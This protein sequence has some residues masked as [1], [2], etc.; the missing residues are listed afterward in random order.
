MHWY[1]AGCGQRY[2]QNLHAAHRWLAIVLPKKENTKT[3]RG[4][5]VDDIK[6]KAGGGTESQSSAAATSPSLPPS[7]APLGAELQ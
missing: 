5:I 3:H 2:C 7:Q 4:E 1:C 6:V